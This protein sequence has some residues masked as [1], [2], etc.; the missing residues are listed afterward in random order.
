MNAS[1]LSRL[2]MIAVLRQRPEID[3]RINLFHCTEEQIT[4]I[5]NISQKEQ[6]RVPRSPDDWGWLNELAN[7]QG[8][9]KEPIGKWTNNSKKT[10]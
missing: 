5:F 3:A 2:D 10:I 4:R 1:K 7:Q 8:M 9:P 6:N